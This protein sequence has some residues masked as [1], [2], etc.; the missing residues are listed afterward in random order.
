MYTQYSPEFGIRNLIRDLGFGTFNMVVDQDFGTAAKTMKKMG[1]SMKTLSAFFNNDQFPA[2]KDGNLLREFMEEGAMTGYT[3]LKTAGEIFEQVQKEIAKADKTNLWRAGGIQTLK[4]IQ[5]FGHGLEV[6]NKTLENAMRFSYYKTLREQGVSKQQAASKAKDLTVN[7]NRKGRN[8]AAIG[9]VFIFFNASVQGTERLLRS[10]VNP[11]TRKKA[12]GFAGAIMATG[13]MQSALHGLFDEEDEDGK[14]FYEKIPDYVRRNNMI[15]PTGDG[16]FIKIPLPYGLN[17]FFSAGESLGRIITGKSDPGKE[18]IGMLSAMTNV[19]SPIGGI[20]FNSEQNGFQ[21]AAQT[22]APS[23]V[24][25]VLDLAFNRNFTGRP[26]YPENFTANQYK[27]PDSQMYFEG[28]NPYLKD[29]TTFLNE[30]T[31]GNEVVPGA[32]DLNPEWIEYGVEQYFGGPVQFGKNLITTLGNV[33]EGQQIFDDPYLR[34]VPFIRSF[35]QKT[36][37]DFEARQ[38][39]YENRDAAIAAKEAYELMVEGA[40]DQDAEQFFK[41]NEK[42]IIL[43]D[44][45]KGYDKIVSQMNQTINEL[46]KTDPEAFDADIEDLMNQRTQIMREFNKRFGEEKFANRPNPLK[47]ILGIN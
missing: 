36:G 2:G 31:G 47:Q 45:Y 39:F 5:A 40:M 16:D 15:I 26:I 22:I 33:A 35:V 14:T 13:M 44:E 19:F 1:K 23:I 9:S 43:A 3:D 27:L 37:T 32:I 6:Y 7:F 46:K 28:V 24:S 18:A 12:W 10:F 21:Q 29:A 11:K 4:P 17:I 30:A 34:S 25:P 41:E 20:E 38:N 8:S 42:L